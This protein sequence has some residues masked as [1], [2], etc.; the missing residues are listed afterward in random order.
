MTT[1][2][3]YKTNYYHNRLF[4]LNDVYYAYIIINNNID[5]NKYIY[6]FELNINKLF[7]TIKNKKKNEQSDYHIKIIKKVNEDNYYSCNVYINKNKLSYIQ[8]SEN[9]TKLNYNE[10]FNLKNNDPFFNTEYYINNN[11]FI[12]K[13]YINNI[14]YINYHWL[15]CGRINPQMYFKYL[16]NKHNDLIINLPLDNFTMNNNNNNTLLFIDNRYDMSFIYLVQ[17]F[18]YSVGNSWNI[19]IFTNNINKAKYEDDLLKLNIDKSFIK[20]FTLN[21]TFNNNIEYSDLLK[22][23]T[24]WE[25][26][27]EDNCLL[28]Q[29]DSFCM[30]KFDKIFFNYN[31]IGARWPHK[32]SY[33]EEITIG[34]GGTSFRKTKIMREMILKYKSSRNNTKKYTSEDVFFAEM[35]YENNLY[36]CTEDVADRFAF[37]NIYNDNS[38]Y[39]HQIYNT[40][41]ME[42]MDKFI[43]DKLYKM[44]AEI[45]RT[46]K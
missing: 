14:Q 22:E 32:A 15:L 41:K 7:M 21:N 31:Y 6:D 29:Y 20:I 9:I 16:L 17:L 3:Y 8:I 43:Y 33:I 28:F 37:E 27:K 10:D 25:Q 26:I 12:N 39:A 5:T 1:Q 46:I 13:R 24:I 44:N 19:T 42:D 4:I 35:L 30:G 2:L 23:I 38:I 40:V 36:N 11:K 18:L 34:N 45:N